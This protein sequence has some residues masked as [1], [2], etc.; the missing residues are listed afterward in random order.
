MLLLVNNIHEK[1]TQQVKT[2]EI[3]KACARYL[4]FALVLQLY[5]RTT[6]E[7]TRFQPIISMQIFHGYQLFF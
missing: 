3:L 2:D 4:Q 1:T 7:R 6:G 5:N